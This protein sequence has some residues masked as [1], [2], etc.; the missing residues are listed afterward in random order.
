M[1]PRRLTLAWTLSL[2]AAAPL[3]ADECHWVYR[4]RTRPECL[5]GIPASNYPYPARSLPVMAISKNGVLLRK[6]TAVAETKLRKIEA[7]APLPDTTI[8]V[9]RASE[10]LPPVAPASA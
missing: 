3:A 6:S 9:P 7:G 5:T 8:P 2:V 10:L 1:N 4:N